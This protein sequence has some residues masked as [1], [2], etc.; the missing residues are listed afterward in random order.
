[1][2][3]LSANRFLPIT[4]A[5]LLIQSYLSA[6]TKPI[7][8]SIGPEFGYA[9]GNF[10]NTHSFGA[11]GSGILYVPVTDHVA[12]VTF[13]GYMHYFQKNNTG[14]ENADANIIP[15]RLGLRY[16]AGKNLYVSGHM[17]YGNVF[18]N[19]TNE[20]G[21][22]YALGLGAFNGNVDFG[23]RYDHIAAFSGVGMIQLRIAWVVRV[24]EREKKKS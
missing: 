24:G 10:H 19:N 20:G 4:F 2:T 5:L 18:T 8:L 17:G 22:S 1:M 9:L 12:A 13:I 23:L 3:N 7:N 11:G 14:V 21:F 15:L 16:S 6:Q